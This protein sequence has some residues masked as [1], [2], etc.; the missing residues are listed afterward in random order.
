MDKDRWIV[1]T[2]GCGFIGTHVLL[3]LNRLGFSNN[4]IVVDDF[5][6][7]IKWKNL[8]HV[9]YA[10]FV[11]RYELFDWLEDRP[12]EV[13]AIIHM[14]A[15]A[16]TTG[17]DGDEYYEMNYRYT[18]ELG[19]I[20]IEEGI[21]FIYASSA[22]TYGDGSLGF[23]DEEIEALRP[24]NL[25]GQSKHMVDLWF[26]R[27]GYRDE[28][29]GLKFFNV[30]GPYEG[31]KG[32]MASM[33]YHMYHQ[34]QKEGKV[35][36]FRS[37]TKQILDGEQQRDFIYVKDVANIVCSFLWNEL[38]GIFNVGIGQPRSFN[39]MAK[40]VF[41]AMD[42]EARL[43]Y[44]PMPEQLI[45]SYQ[46][47]TCADMSKLEKFMDLPKTPLEAGVND[48]VRNYLLRGGV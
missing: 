18:V 25:Y 41:E 30:Y 44:I 37:N 6:E 1:V 42:A 26:F 21:R 14:G 15:N 24:M 17:I 32:T 4:V 31:H 3:E 23:S 13:Q 8:R 36:L 9:Q 35:R 48:Y 12:G 39:A 43:E 40:A 22:A 20:A 46:N 45:K 10:D 29:V 27:N 2:G 47:Y 7:S 28:V 16:S 19:K 33:V 38:T 34:I 5:K 11:S